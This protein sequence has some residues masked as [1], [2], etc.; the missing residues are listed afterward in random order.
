MPES[1]LHRLAEAAVGIVLYSHDQLYKHTIHIH[2]HMQ[3]HN[4]HNNDERRHFFRKIYL[5]LYL[6]GLC[7]R[8]NWR[9][10]RNATYWHPLYWPSVFLSRSPGLF[11]RG[12][13]A[14][15]LWVLVFSPASYLQLVWSPNWLNFLCTALYNS[16]T[17]TFFLRV[18]QFRTNS[19]CPRSRL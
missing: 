5:S 19:T 14:Q 16:S 10:N 4:E 8:G 1:Q 2:L 3:N 11:N 18:S 7:V 9:P 12:P 6:K 17:P 13:G 15:L